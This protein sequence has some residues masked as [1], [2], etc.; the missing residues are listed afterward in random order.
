MS[1]REVEIPTFQVIDC[2][3]QFRNCPFCKLSSGLSLGK[4]RVTI[5][6]Q[7]SPSK[8]RAK[9]GVVTHLLQLVRQKLDFFFIFILLFRILWEKNKPTNPKGGP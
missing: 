5:L 1:L 9:L 3:L 6:L 8:C 2:L 4:K 7:I